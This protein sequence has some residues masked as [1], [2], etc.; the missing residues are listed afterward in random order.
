MTVVNG[1]LQETAVHN[2][3]VLY[4][5]LVSITMHLAAAL[6]RL[7]QTVALVKNIQV[8]GQTHQR[9][10][11]HQVAVMLISVKFGRPQVGAQHKK[12][13][14]SP[15]LE[16][17][18]MPP[19]VAPHHHVLMR[20]LVRNMMLDGQIRQQAVQCQAVE[21]LGTDDCGP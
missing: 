11:Q 8:D 13:V 14:N 20:V 4:P 12:T 15:Q 9:R 3:T 19:D 16:S 7:V 18:M 2:L 1:Q 5:R 10:A 21:T 6:H 17:I